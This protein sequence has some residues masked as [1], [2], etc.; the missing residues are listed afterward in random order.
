MDGI[1]V[2]NESVVISSI[3][4]G[5]N[6]N[7]DMEEI[8]DYNRKIEN[9]LP[10]RPDKKCFVGALDVSGRHYRFTKE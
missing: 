6:I 2:L 1:R 5:L 4:N 9:N 3:N 7:E 8:A 10:M